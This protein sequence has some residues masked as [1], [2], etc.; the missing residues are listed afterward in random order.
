[1]IRLLP[2]LSILL[3]LSLYPLQSLADDSTGTELIDV[4]DMH[5]AQY[6]QPPLNSSQINDCD[7][8]KYLSIEYDYTE[9][10]DVNKALTIRDNQNQIVAYLQDYDEVSAQWQYGYM[11]VLK[12]N[13]VGYI[14]F[15]GKQAIPPLY[16]NSHPYNDEADG[17]W[18]NAV[19]E[20][21]VVV[22]QNGRY[23]IIDIENNLILSFDNPY[24]FIGDIKEN[25]A[26]IML[27]AKSVDSGQWGFIDK[28]GKPVIAPEYDALDSF[29]TTPYGFYQGLTGVKKDSKWGFIDTS[30]KTIIPIIYDDIESFNN[31]LAGVRLGDKWGFINKLNQVVIP[32][33][34]SESKVIRNK[35]TFMGAHYFYFAED[36]QAEVPASNGKITCINK[37]GIEEI[38]VGKNIS[39]EDKYIDYETGVCADFSGEIIDC[40]E[41]EVEFAGDTVCL[42]DSDDEIPC[43]EEVEV[44]ANLLG[45]I[46]ECSKLKETTM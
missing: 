1:M 25:R 15:D 17:F 14:T 30:G 16:D 38:C 39:Y 40:S 4:T 43:V 35:D 7:P 41:I 42:S 13:K 37:S 45:E 11:P 31:G 20:D 10:M 5:Y 21:R 9:K 2:L 27:Q 22:R 34:Y 18:A 19:Y 3:P 33:N 26:P 8:F 6:C 24:A 36:S 46:I 32:F 23:G 44:C 29:A 12:N 28:N